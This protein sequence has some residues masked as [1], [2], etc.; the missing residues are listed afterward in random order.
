[1]HLTVIW[2]HCHHHKII[3]LPFLSHFLRRV[4]SRYAEY[5]GTFMSVSLTVGL[6]I[7]SLFGFLLLKLVWN[8]GRSF[9]TEW[10]TVLSVYYSCTIWS[11]LINLYFV[12]CSKFSIIWRYIHIFEENYE[13]TFKWLWIDL[14]MIGKSLGMAIVDQLTKI[15]LKIWW[16]VTNFQLI[17]H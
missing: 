16:T 13:S 12:L 8:Q 17:N 6:A 9:G 11:D 7:G 1:M 2:S 5:A 14:Q 15:Q 10:I 3:F 4:E